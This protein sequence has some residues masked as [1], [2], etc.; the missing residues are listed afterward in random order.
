MGSLSTSAMLMTP[1]VT[2][3]WVCLNRWLSTISGDD[4]PAEL[5]DD[6]HAVPVRFVAQVGDAFDALVLDQLGD[7][8]D[9]LGLVD[10]VG[11]L[12]DDDA[13]PPLLLLHDGLGPHLDLAAAGL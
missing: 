3:I 10:L 7:G 12:V 11:D 13:L 5:D 6:A 8:L 1:K 2:S 4:V 9:E